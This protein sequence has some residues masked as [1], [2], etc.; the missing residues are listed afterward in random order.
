MDAPYGHCRRNQGDG[1]KLPPA[2][3]GKGLLRLGRP[4][5]AG[6]LL[7]S[8]LCVVFLASAL[9]G[10]LL[11]GAMRVLAARWKLVDLPNAR[12]SHATPTAR[13]GGVAIVLVTLI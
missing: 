2:V 7:I 11:V 13:G 3:S 10:W 12:S 9:A 8:L 4:I 5:T 1:A 6:R